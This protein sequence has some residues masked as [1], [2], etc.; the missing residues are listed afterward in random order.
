MTE[1]RKVYRTIRDAR[2]ALALDAGFDPFV[3][4][5]WGR[6]TKARLAAAGYVVDP[7][8]WRRQRDE[9]KQRIQ[10][11]M[12]RECGAPSERQM[13]CD[14]HSIGN[15][16]LCQPKHTG[17]CHEHTS[18][19]YVCDNGHRWTGTDAEDAARDHRCPTCGE[20]WV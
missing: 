11:G 18:Y 12:C 3:S 8:E 13:V 15:C 10:A 17:Y 4:G 7:A 16:G 6:C 9:R 1:T 14:E 20:H 2:N 19:S 5:G